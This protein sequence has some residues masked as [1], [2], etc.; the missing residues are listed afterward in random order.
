MHRIDYKNKVINFNYNNLK[1]TVPH[2][3][4]KNRNFVLIPLKEILPDWK[5]PKSKENIDSLV[6]K[7]PQEDRK[8]I[9]KI[10]NN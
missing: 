1:F 9:L 4:L 5:H 6:E 8:S 10:K 7:L 3:N 2:K